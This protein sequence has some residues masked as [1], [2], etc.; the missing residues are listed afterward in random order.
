MVRT[1]PHCWKAWVSVDFRVDVLLQVP[2]E[3]PIDVAGICNAIAFWFELDLDAET[4][5]STS[6]YSDKV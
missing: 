4:T 2:L 5:L 6:P 3:L 1:L